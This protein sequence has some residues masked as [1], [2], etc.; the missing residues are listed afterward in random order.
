MRQT[1]PGSG[2]ILQ[3]FLLVFLPLTVLLL[4]ITF[5][6]LS[7]HRSAMRNMVAGRDE[8]VVR[9][10]A[11]ALQAQLDYRLLEIEGLARR[12]AGLPD[13]SLDDV[14]HRSEYLLGSFPGGFALFD[15]DGLVLAHTENPEMLGWLSSN[16]SNSLRPGVSQGNP[17]I[18]TAFQHPANGEFANLVTFA[19]DKRIAVGVFFPKVLVETILKQAFP[20]DHHTNILVVDA[21]ANILYLSGTGAVSAEVHSHPGVISALGGESGAIYLPIDGNQQIIAYSPVQP[22]GWGL[23]VQEAAEMVET[24]LLS[25]TQMAPL[26]LVPAL[27]IALLALF[28]GARQ[29]VWPLQA[30]EKQSAKL[31]WG[32]FNAIQESVG[33]IA[34]IR[35]LQAG[36][37][38]MAE[39]VKTA[40]QGLHN[41]IGAIT[42]GQEDE[43]RRLARELH[44]ETLQGLIALKQRVQLLQISKNNQ[45]SSPPLTEIEAL[46]EQTIQDLRRLVRALRPIYLEDLGLPAALEMLSQENTSSTGVEIVFEKIGVEQRQSPDIELALYR[47]TQEAMNNAIRHSQA[48]QIRVTTHYTQ[49]ALVLEVSDDGTGF[50]IPKSPAEFAPS[51]HF[52]LLGLHERAE[53]IGAQLNIS[54]DTG[55]GTSI[56]VILPN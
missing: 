10:A 56:K 38:H 52:G 49:D 11:S 21:T 7:L 54:S 35:S 23:V 25:S 31:A 33:G 4:L 18:S 51:G 39:K 16:I 30:L 22:V 42:V 1:A 34:E 27:L 8:Q 41:Y 17:A 13:E 24:P 50:Q 32:D 40:Q 47:I 20:A 26:I 15:Q 29:V 3:L 44:D 6:S 36:L 14:I 37:I 19:Y 43:R 48:H 53:L 55:V 9:T 45:S 46:A 12:A 2:L 5:G 28:F